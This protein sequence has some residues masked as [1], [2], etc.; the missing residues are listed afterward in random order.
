MF[1]APRRRGTFDILTV[2]LP[3][4][5]MRQLRYVVLPSKAVTFLEAILSKNGPDALPAADAAA[6]AADWR[7]CSSIRSRLLLVRCG[8]RAVNELLA[9]PPMMPLPTLPLLLLLLLPLLL[10]PCGLLF[11]AVAADAA[12]VPTYSL[13][14]VFSLCEPDTAL[15]CVCVGVGKRK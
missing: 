1:L 8:I 3:K 9:A 4:F 10:L 6:A 12:D 13:T 5:L 11:A 7:C 14:L 15:A 2:L